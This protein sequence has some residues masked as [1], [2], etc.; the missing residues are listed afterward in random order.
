MK[1]SGTIAVI[2]VMILAILNG[3]SNNPSQT[4]AS[5]SSTLVSSSSQQSESQMSDHL[6]N[7]P[8]QTKTYTLSEVQ[9]EMPIP[10]H[11]MNWEFSEG[12]CLFTYN[13]SY[14]YLNNNGKVVIEPIYQIATPFSEGLAVT[15]S[16]N[17]DSKITVINSNG[18]GLFDLNGYVI[19]NNMNNTNNAL[20]CSCY[21]Q[22]RLILK[23]DYFNSN[24]YSVLDTSGKKIYSVGGEP[25][26]TSG[27]G[28][29][30]AI[31][32]NYYSCE[33]MVWE[34]WGTEKFVRIVD[35]EGN[36]IT[37][38]SSGNC[39]NSR[40]LYNDNLLSIPNKDNQWGVVDQNGNT[41]I[42]FAFEELGFAGD[43]RIPF[44]KYGKWGYMDYT[45]QIVIEAQYESATEFNTGLAAVKLNNSV[46]YI[47][48]NGEYVIQPT[49]IYGTPFFDN[50]TAV[51]KSSAGGEALI[52]SE[53]NLITPES[54][55][56]II[57]YG[58]TYGNMVIIGKTS[59]EGFSEGFKIYR[60]E[61]LK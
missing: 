9:S 32:D 10:K 61:E 38:I 39:L 55:G 37:E 31:P 19:F 56:Q 52:D 58:N 8:K 26:Y 16:K 24:T 48:I 33:R 7:T 43:G 35:K 11:S 46:G 60:I 47:D 44:K 4:S 42:D 27:N 13:N 54:Y 18:E 30:I 22:G 53:G 20:H 45:G 15:Y 1:K 25:P 41:V 2:F 17:P 28:E 21:H 12:L 51:I 23:E 29:P 34:I 3:C 40:L 57:K 14:G 36:V 5:E 59:R 6:G 50:G 49:W